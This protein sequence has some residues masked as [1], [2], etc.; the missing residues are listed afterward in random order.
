MKIES[1][2]LALPSRKVTNEDVID[3]IRAESTS[4]VGDLDKILHVIGKTLRKT[5]TDVRYWIDGES[6]TSLSVTLKAAQEA[7]EEAPGEIDL[8]IYASVYNELVEPASSN[9]I[10]FELG[11]PQAECFDI[12]EACD[13]WVKA[14]KIAQSLMITDSSYR[15]V[16]IIND[17]FSMRP[18]YAIR[19]QLF[20]LDSP[21]QLQNRFPA[22]TIGEGATA[23][24]VSKSGDNWKF[25]SKT[26]NE[27]YDLCTVTPRYYRRGELSAKVGVDG[28]GLFTS[29]AGAL[30]EKG[31]PLA[32]ET[33]D[34]SGINSMHVSRLFTHASST[35]DWTKISMAIALHN[36]WYDIHPLTGNLV[37]ASI[38]AAMAMAVND[39]SL[40]RG[41]DVAVLCASAGMTFSTAH[42]EF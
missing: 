15:R 12:K 40:E 14:M 10:A 13:G 26:R 19:P 9:L 42:F 7:I 1:I 24:I 21:K 11:F 27:Y 5:G 18:Q 3:E 38:P 41:H 16:L 25:T 35:A 34:L 17:E 29:W 31:I 37:S 8:V 22:F 23:T 32:I 33:F 2:K 20:C 4:F 6:E 39:G 28:P 30:S 36:R